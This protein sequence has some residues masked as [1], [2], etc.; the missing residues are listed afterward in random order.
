MR[1]ASPDQPAEASVARGFLAWDTHFD[2]PLTDAG[3]NTQTLE[4]GDT[5]TATDS[6][7][8]KQH[9]VLDVTFDDLDATT[10]TAA[11]T[12]PAG[13]Q[14]H[15][16][17]WDETGD[18]QLTVTTDA[19]SAW[20]ADFSSVPFDIVNSTEGEA[21]VAD[22]DGDGTVA[23][24][25]SEGMIVEPGGWERVSLVSDAHACEFE[26]GTLTQYEIDPAFPDPYFLQKYRL[27]DPRPNDTVKATLLARPSGQTLPYF[28]VDPSTPGPDAVT[29]EQRYS[30]N[31]TGTADLEPLWVT[32]VSI[33][34]VRTLDGDLVDRNVQLIQGIDENGQ[35]I[36]VKS[37]GVCG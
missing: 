36:V 17:L 7:T 20:L 21:R 35:E 23:S 10:D 24:F 9:Q 11:G 8:T 14:V 4:P 15:V 19:S 12:A 5:V 22:D 2:T 25:T 26:Q 34:T 27:S 32:G 18:A 29:V 1:R 13:E 31:Y 33:S 30:L 3:G 28:K 16:G 37:S 6:A